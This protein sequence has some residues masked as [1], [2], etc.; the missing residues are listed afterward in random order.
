M[1]SENLPKWFKAHRKKLIA[2]LAATLAAIGVVSCVSINRVAVVPPHIPGATFVGS[3]TCEDCHENITKGFHTATHAR[4]QAEGANA[5][6]VGCE[7]CHGAGSIHNEAGG[8]SNNIVNPKKS[9]EACF[10]CHLDKRSSF[11]LPYHHPIEDGKVT[12]TD[13]HNPHKGPA[14]KSGGTSM[15]AENETCFQCH[16]QQRG[17]FVFEHE[18]SREGCLTCHNPHG[19]VNPKMLTERNANLCLKCHFQ[20]QVPGTDAVLIGGFA[21]SSRLRQG[22]C[23]SA[24]CH[25]AVH[26]SQVHSSL[27]Y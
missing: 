25:E 27:R 8:G 4:L 24:G 23:W 18:A 26:G 1:K 6:E 7:S 17:P 10:Q 22:T 15:A 21:H 11:N 13:C 3:K 5:T 19:T 2:A 9:P 20:Q 14:I 16:A 12:C